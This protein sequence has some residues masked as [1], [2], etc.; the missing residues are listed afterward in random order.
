MKR[1]NT[2]SFTIAAHIEWTGRII[3]S[4]INILPVWRPVSN[5][6]LYT[7]AR[8]TCVS[9]SAC[10]VYPLFSSL[11]CGKLKTK[12]QIF[13]D[14]ACFVG[15]P[16]RDKREHSCRLP[17]RIACTPGKLLCH[18]VMSS[19]RSLSSHCIFMSQCQHDLSQSLCDWL[20]V[21]YDRGL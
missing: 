17:P 10:T 21:W 2:F 13:I 9:R 5:V 16:A 18:R 14:I 7:Y 11:P 8:P 15:L 3:W 6:L 12:T 19:P 1:K 4:V 20:L